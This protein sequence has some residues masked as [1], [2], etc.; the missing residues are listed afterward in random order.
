MKK[1]EFDFLKDTFL[2]RRIGENT[3][4]EIY[5]TAKFTIR[6]FEKGECIFSPFSFDKSIGFVK[7][8]ACVVCRMHQNGSAVPLND[9]EKNGTFGIIAVLTN[10]EYPTHIYAKRK[11]TIC[12]LSKDDFL[13]LFKKYSEIAINTAEFLAGRIN[14]LNNKINTFSSNTVEEKLA[15]YI[16]S[17]SKK[18]NASE[19]VFNRKHSAEAINTG[20]ASLYRALTS[21]KEA[22]LINYDTKKIYIIDQIG[23]ER[24]SK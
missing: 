8:G 18:M 15:H 10:D 11:C 17:V 22:G 12:F 23:L 1:S 24:K 2:F 4:S 16:L 21:L 19:F 6:S 5:Q 20:R 3:M 13:L 7:D 14:F 9:I